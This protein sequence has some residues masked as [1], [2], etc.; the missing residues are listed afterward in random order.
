[1]KNR[2]MLL[3]AVP[4][5]PLGVPLHPRPSAQSG[6]LQLPLSFADVSQW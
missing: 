4:L 6:V 5:H 1:M 2:R 3:R